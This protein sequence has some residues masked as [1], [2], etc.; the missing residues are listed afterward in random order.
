MRAFTAFFATF[1]A[2]FSTACFASDAAVPTEVTTALAASATALPICDA[3]SLRLSNEL[4]E[5]PPSL[6][7]GVPLS[8]FCEPD[9]LNGHHEFHGPDA[10]ATDVR[11]LH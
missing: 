5:L 7:M 6:C 8:V 10:Y 9:G 11:N 4:P 1:F 2:V 3:P